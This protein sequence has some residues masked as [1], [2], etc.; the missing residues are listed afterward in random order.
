[1]PFGLYDLVMS[2]INEETEKWLNNMSYVDD[3]IEELIGTSNY[4]NM[5]NNERKTIAKEL[6]S[7]LKRDGY[8]EYYS[9]DDSMCSFTYKG[10]ALGGIMLEDFNPYLKE[11]PMD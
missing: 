6:L 4:K 5:T 11:I 8:I 1:M 2:K 9:C 10:G 3:K 7:S